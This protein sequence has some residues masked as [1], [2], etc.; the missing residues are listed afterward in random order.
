MI[1]SQYQKKYA[2]VRRPVS[3][4]HK[5]KRFLGFQSI[6]YAVTVGDFQRVRIPSGQS[7]A[8]PE[9]TNS[10]RNRKSLTYRYV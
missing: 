1:D 8:R 6:E 7:V 3:C 9:P 10:V 5:L 4:P 2:D